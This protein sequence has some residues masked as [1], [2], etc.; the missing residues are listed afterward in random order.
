[1]TTNILIARQTG[2]CLNSIRDR[3][4]IFLC[5]K[6]SLFIDFV[7]WTKLVYY[8]IITYVK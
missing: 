7:F 6:L 4:K 5:V 3:I 1:M 2:T 8:F